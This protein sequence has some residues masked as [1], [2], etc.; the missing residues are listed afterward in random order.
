[1]SE[2]RFWNRNGTRTAYALACGY[3]EIEN[4]KTGGKI[5]L[6]YESEHYHVQFIPLENREKFGAL[7]LNGSK[8]EVFE[9]LTDAR[10]AYKHYKGL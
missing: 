10:K 5:E 1:M 9:L 4:T 3:K 7:Y 2:P 6:F 8:W